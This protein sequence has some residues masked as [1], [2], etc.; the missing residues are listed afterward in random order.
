MELSNPLQLGFAQSRD[1]IVLPTLRLSVTGF[2][3]FEQFASG[4]DIEF[5]PRQTRLGMCSIHGLE[6]SSAVLQLEATVYLLA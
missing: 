4:R 6:T 1:P 5:E 3:L 2:V